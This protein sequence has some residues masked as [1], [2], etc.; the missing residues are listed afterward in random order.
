[1]RTFQRLNRAGQTR[2]QLWARNPGLASASAAHNLRKLPTARCH[3]FHWQRCRWVSWLALYLWL[4]LRLRLHRGLQL[5]QADCPSAAR[6][7]CETSTAQHNVCQPQSSSSSWSCSSSLPRLHELH[8]SSPNCTKV[9]LALRLQLERCAPAWQDISCA[10]NF[11][12]F[13]FAGCDATNPRR[14]DAT[15]RSMLLPQLTMQQ[16]TQQ[17]LPYPSL[18][19]NYEFLNNHFAWTCYL[20]HCLLCVEIFAILSGECDVDA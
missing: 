11:A 12:L 9:C 6:H 13:M 20:P 1:M 2:W 19:W 15:R 3:I 4:P 17:D 16:N 5:W 8:K 14:R 7:R 10:R 18:L